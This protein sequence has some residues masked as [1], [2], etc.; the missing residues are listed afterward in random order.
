MGPEIEF[1]FRSLTRMIYVVTDEEDQF[2]NEFHQKMKKIEARTWVFNAALGLVPIAQIMK[3]WQTRAHQENRE[4]QDIHSAL[5][6]IYKDDPKEEQNFY[7]ITDPERYLREEHVQRRVLNI[8]HQ[9]HN[10]IK[11]VKILIF[12]GSRKFIPEKLSRYIEVVHE[13]GLDA[14]AIQ[15]LV[16]DTCARLKLE[17]PPDAPRVF[18]GLTHYECVASIAQSFVKTRK[19]TRNI[20]PVHIAEFKRN[21]LKKSDLLQYVESDTTFEDVGG[22]DRFKSWAMETKASW[23]EAGRKYG[24]KPPKGVL[25]V[26]VWGCGK[27]LSVK[28]MG[29]AW[30]LPVVQLEMGRL[31]SSGVGE[32]EANVYRAI[33]MIEAVAPCVTGETE[34]TLADGSVMPIETLWQESPKDLRVMCWNERSLRVETTRV[35]AITRR[36]SEAFC[37]S[38]ANGFRLNATANH[39]HYVLRGGMPE[40]VRTDELEMGDMLAVPLATHDGNPDCLQFHPEGMRVYSKDGKRYPQKYVDLFGSHASDLQRLLDAECRWVEIN[41]PIH[42]VGVQPVYDLVCAGED[43][44]SFFANGLVTHNCLIWV[45]EAEKSLSG[46]ASSGASDAGTTSRTIGILSTWLQETKAP[47]CMAMTANSL[48]TMP[49]EFV[50]RMDERFFFD[51]PS[52][53]ERMAIFK[54][55]LRKAGQTPDSYGLATLAEKAD[56]MVGRELEQAIQA[57]L[58]KSFNA[59]C[60]RLDEGILLEVL[61]TKPRIFRTMADEMKEILD[62]VGWDDEAQEG[63]RARFASGNRITSLQMVQGA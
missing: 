59:G 58:I 21:Q 45:D 12:V 29:S 24:L 52:E 23:T 41:Q 32:S 60:P 47:I 8:A 27:S 33:R 28:A 42:S 15:T 3:D 1:L 35:E 43:T 26:G 6:Q 49:V 14:E 36:E 16:N 31:R 17:V 22:N 20:D 44:H 4:C 2:I 10:N 11:T 62:W 40:W 48:K 37:V 57:A 13:R 25:A 50:N 18:Q 7:I 61:A 56:K 38:A 54:I 51:I 34:V 19:T 5:I 63:I 53:D 39:L 30:N 55:H 46:N 9:L